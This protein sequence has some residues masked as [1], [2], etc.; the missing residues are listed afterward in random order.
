MAPI[1]TLWGISHQPQTKVILSVAALNELELEQPEWTSSNK[2]ADFTSKFPYGKIPAFEGSDGFKLIEGSP[3][4]RYLCDLGTKVKL[5]GSDTKEIAIVN[6]WI[7]FAEE[8]IGS[9][10]H[11]IIG[12]IFSFSKEPFSPEVGALNRYGERM[13]RALTYVESHLATRPSGYLVSESVTLADL[14]LAAVVYG[15]SH[16]TLGAAERAKYPSIYA[17]FAKVSSDA[18]IKHLWRTER[19]AEVA[20]T[21]P[22]PMPRD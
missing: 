5:L 22:V 9:P 13:N 19:F 1:G 11:D 16:A 2:P 8:E 3:I 15:P 6:Q 21:E 7:H 10:G 18:K 20:I 4:A 14:F 12:L 17:H